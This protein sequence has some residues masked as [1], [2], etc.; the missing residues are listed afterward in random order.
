VFTRKSPTKVEKEEKREGEVKI[1]DLEQEESVHVENFHFL[2]ELS[3]KSP[4]Y[5]PWKNEIR[6]SHPINLMDDERMDLENHSYD[7]SES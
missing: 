6:H 3:L 4:I 5:I 2:D 1:E 7:Y